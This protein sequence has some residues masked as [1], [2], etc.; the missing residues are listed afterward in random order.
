MRIALY[1]GDVELRPGPKWVQAFFADL[2]G[3]EIP[4]PDELTT[5]SD[6]DRDD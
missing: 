4:D 2:S 1:G 6:T 3:T 5:Q